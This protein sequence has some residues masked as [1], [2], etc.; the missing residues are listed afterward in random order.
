ML[1]KRHVTFDVS[2]DA[3]WAIIGD[4][5]RVDWV[6]S[7]TR[8]SFSGDRRIM[9]MEGAGRVVEQIFD[10]EA[11]KHLVRYG[12]V[13]SSAPLA[14]HQA[15]MQLKVLGP[16]QTELH[17]QTDVEPDAFAPFIEQGMDAGIEGLQRLLR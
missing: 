8:S 14:K 12:V 3:L 4:P 13:E 6:P 15:Q 10:L 1:I 7:I 9:E 11:A 17:W 5:A 16:K 2:I